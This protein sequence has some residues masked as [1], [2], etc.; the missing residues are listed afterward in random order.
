MVNDEKSAGRALLSGLLIGGVVWAASSAVCII[1]C[2]V[3]SYMNPDPEKLMTPLGI[4]A[5]Y[6]SAFAGGA[7]AS[8]KGKLLSSAL[9]GGSVLAVLLTASAMKP[10]GINTF[11]AGVQALMYCL[12]VVSALLGGIA[13]SFVAGRRNTSPRRRKKRRRSA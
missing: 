5:L 1:L 8:V 6:A 11:G 9:L 13:A 10:D 3:I 7:V 2:A 12:T 4:A